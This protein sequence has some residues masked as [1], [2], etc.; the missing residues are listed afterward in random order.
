VPSQKISFTLSA[1]LAR[2]Q[3]PTPENGSNFNYS[4]PSAASP[5]IPLRL[6]GAPHK[7]NYAECRIMLSLRW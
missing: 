3:K 7:R 1:R 2:K 5:S 4:F 6:C